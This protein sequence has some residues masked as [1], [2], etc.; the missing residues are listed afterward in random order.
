MSYERE[1]DESAD[2]LSLREQAVLEYC[3]EGIG[4][5]EIAVRLQ[6]SRREVAI[7]RDHAATKLMARIASAHPFRI[8]E[9]MLARP[10]GPG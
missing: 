10:L 9:V 8:R 2:A 4:D 1:P 5:N 6:M 7:I 3:A